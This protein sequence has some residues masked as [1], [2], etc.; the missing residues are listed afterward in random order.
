[1]TRAEDLIDRR[2]EMSALE[3]IRVASSCC[4][5]RVWREEHAGL[6]QI[7]L[8]WQWDCACVALCVELCLSVLAVLCEL[9]G[10]RAPATQ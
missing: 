9:R 3:F 8:T 4:D 6:R 7:S 10:R 1:M 5:P 2:V